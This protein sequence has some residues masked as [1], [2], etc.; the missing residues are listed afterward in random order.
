M[1]WMNRVILGVHNSQAQKVMWKFKLTQLLFHH[2][3]F[4]MITILLRR[5]GPLR[6]NNEITIFDTRA[7]NPDSDIFR[8]QS[9][10]IFSLQ[11][12]IKHKSS[13]LLALCEGNPPVTGGFPS[14]RASNIDRMF[15]SWHHHHVG[16]IPH[17]SIYHVSASLCVANR[18][19]N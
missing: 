6:C 13:A 10:H 4:C 8:S 14:Q 17:I 12:Q 18:K 19:S 15:M 1:C 3:F 2:Y 16:N 5:K 11:W 7:W 9:M